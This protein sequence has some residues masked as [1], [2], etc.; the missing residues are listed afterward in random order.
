MAAGQ[1]HARGSEPCVLL[2]HDAE[3]PIV[4]VLTDQDLAAVAD[5]PDARSSESRSCYEE[6][7]HNQWKQLPE[8]G[9]DCA[10]GLS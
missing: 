3:E 8:L 1:S 6:A 9:S 2:V 7:E 5:L 4:H 10:S